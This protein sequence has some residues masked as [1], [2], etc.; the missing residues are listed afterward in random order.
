MSGP[1]ALSLRPR[2]SRVDYRILANSGRRI[3]KETTT[4]EK[5]ESSYQNLSLSSNMA[6][7]NLIDDEKRI[8]L[9]IERYFKE[10]TFDL[11]FDIEDIEK[12][13]SEFRELIENFEEIHVGLKRE[14]EDDYVTDYP[15]F[16]TLY[17]RLT[18]WVQSAER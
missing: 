2:K 10:F 14:L 9:K 4:L 18:G 15:D 16:D 11:M 7:Q 5:I 1:K 3:T 6:L 17:Q 12:G 13:I 8:C